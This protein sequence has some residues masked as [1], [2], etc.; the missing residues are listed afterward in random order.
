[1]VNTRAKNFLA[2]NGVPVKFDSEERLL[3][4]KF[5]VVDGQTVVVG[6]HNWSIGSFFEFDDVSLAIASATLA[7]EFTGRFDLLWQGS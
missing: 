6:S 5:V 1:M 7:Q 3:H 4:S 2:A